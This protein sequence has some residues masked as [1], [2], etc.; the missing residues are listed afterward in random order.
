MSD[1]QKYRSQELERLRLDNILKIIPKG[2]GSVLEIGTR[3]GHHARAL[4]EHFARVV[5][6]DLVMP[7]FRIERVIPMEGDVTRL[8]FPDD[9]FDCVVCAEVLEH[10]PNVEKAASEIAR[11]SKFDVVVGVPYKQDTR[12]GRL[13]CSECGKVNP[14]WGHVNTF[15]EERLRELFKTLMLYNIDYVGTDKERTNELSKW[16]MDCAG[17]PWGSYDQDEPC[18]YC[19]SP[20]SETRPVRTLSQ[21]LCSTAAHQL[22]IL[23]SL[24]TKPRPNWIHAVF[25]KRPFPDQPSG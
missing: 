13:T 24:F 18:I 22:N 16:L 7:T 15:D 6:L 5:A 17:N 20:F 8:E 9:S 4:T 12:I 19:G 1:L 10:I 25:S 2:R 3:D 14:P 11:V 23:Q 21:K